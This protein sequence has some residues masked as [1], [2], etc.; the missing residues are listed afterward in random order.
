MSTVETTQEARPRKGRARAFAKA[1]GRFLFAAVTTYLGLLAVTFFI[2]RV[3]PI[4]PVLAILGDRAPNHVVERVR[5]EMGFNLP[6]YQQFFLYIKGILSGD[7]GNSVLTTNPVMVD[8]RRVLPA[9]IELA[10]L[11]TLIGALVGVPLGVLAAVRRGSI[12][13]QVV[14][15]VGLVGY[16]VPIFWLALISLVIFY[17]R[18][19]W[20]AFPGR[21]DIVF[22]YTFTPITG[23]YL[24]DSAWQGQWDVFYDVFR[25]IILPAS[26]LGYF[27]LAYISRMTRSFMLN[28]LSQE[29]IVA[30]RAKGLSETRVI[31]G[32]ALRNAAVPLVTVI[33]L[34]YAGLLEGS[35]LTETVFS[36]PGIGLYITNSLQNAD[37]NA[38]L[39]GTIV[40]GTVFIGINLLSDLLYRTLDPRTR[41]R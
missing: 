10:T 2:G 12:A 28:E 35:V 34:S 4:D 17:A 22:E 29:Y 3:V 7:F 33:A 18:L 16:S 36:W 19:R 41:N 9:T 40:I 30:A 8:I 37:M 20:V 13:D 27:S 38:V 21:I 11:G 5:Q 31:W 14:R 26:L 1:L 24:L 23:L 39:G 15:V 6:L 32:H 25:H